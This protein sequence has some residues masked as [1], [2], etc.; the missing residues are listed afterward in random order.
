M[1]DVLSSLQ[2]IYAS[3]LALAGPDYLH[4][5]HRRDVTL[6]SRLTGAAPAR[7]SGSGRVPGAQRSLSMWTVG[8]DAHYRLYVLCVLDESG[9]VV[10]ERTIRGGPSA[11]ANFLRSLG[12]PARVCFE[13]SCGYGT[14]H[15]ALAAVAKEVTVAHPGQLRLIFRS[16]QKH[17]R[18]DAR[19]LAKLL[20]LGEVPP[21]HV[22]ASE[23]RAW[24]ALIEF[25]RGLVMKQTRAKNTL[26]ALLRSHGLAM[27][28]GNVLWT[29]RGVEWAA[30]VELSAMETLKRDLLLKE[31]AFYEEA[32]KDAEKRL[33]GF[34]K[35]RAGVALLQT[36]P[37]VGARTAEAFAAYVDDPGRFTR[38]RQA[39]AYFGLV[40]SL[41]QSAGKARYGR[42]TRE[43]PGTVR[44]ML[45]EAAWQAIR[46]S[47]SL[48]AFHERVTHGKKERKA[49]AVIAT[50]RHLAEVM[51]AMM[52]SGEP[53][54][55]RAE[56][57]TAA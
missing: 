52:R 46:R 23:V 36:I 55:E 16:K 43:G 41:D 13:A 22:P 38:S 40:P 3:V 18:V 39:G 14:L 33:N 30:A 15:D 53:W 25:R 35:E 37:G 56:I 27:P 12:E 9:E 19:K 51:L 34:A 17:D 10:Q 1:F 42:I 5:G 20:H 32:I 8:I 48:R 50:A 24:R 6:W 4:H 11:V 54:R 29:R 49:L 45:T 7:A 2:A 57:R 31:I 47:P 44:G 21:V 28:R 26:R